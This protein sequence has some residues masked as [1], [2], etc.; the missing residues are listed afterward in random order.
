MDSLKFEPLISFTARCQWQLDEAPMH[1]GQWDEDSDLLR[2]FWVEFDDWNGNDGWLITSADY[3]E[4]MIQ[5]FLIDQLLGPQ[6]RQRRFCDSFWFGV[7]RH[8][9]GFFYEV[10][11]AYEGDNVDSWPLLDYWLNVSRNGYLGFYTAR[12]PAGKCVTEQARLEVRDPFGVRAGMTLPIEP[13]FEIATPLYTLT[14][15]RG[16]PLW[17]VPELDP[18]DLEAGDVLTNLT[19]H[20]PWGRRVRRVAE[21]VAYLNDHQGTSGRFSLVIQNPCVPPHPKPKA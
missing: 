9:T 11:P 3:S 4:E 7:Y 15:S 2:P 6:A 20:S 16:T 21:D 5:S 8:A 14:C 17:H 18:S 13:P 10:R 1:P 19:L 12:S